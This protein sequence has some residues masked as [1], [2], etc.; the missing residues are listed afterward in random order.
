MSKLSMLEER[1]SAHDKPKENPFK[2]KYQ[3]RDDL[4]EALGDFSKSDEIKR[5]RDSNPFGY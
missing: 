5:E 3:R 1:I 4:R 2:E